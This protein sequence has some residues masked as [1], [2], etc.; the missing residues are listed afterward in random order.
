[1]N[2]EQLDTYCETQF[3]ATDN[4]HRANAYRKVDSFIHTEHPTRERMLTE[5]AETATKA[6]QTLEVIQRV[7]YALA[8]VDTYQAQEDVCEELFEL[9]LQPSR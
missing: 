7:G 1:M 9:L 4:A 3:R 6:Q 8:M 2:I 5:L